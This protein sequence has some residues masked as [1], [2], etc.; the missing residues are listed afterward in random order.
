[1][2]NEDDPVA[3]WKKAGQ[4]QQKMADWL[5]SRDQ[6]TLTG[7]NVALK[8]SL[9]NASSSLRWAVQLPGWGNFHRPGGRL[10]G[11]WVRFKYPAIE[12]GQEVTDIQLWFEQGRVVKEAA[13]KNQELLTAQ[14][15][16]DAGARTLANSDW[17]QLWYHAFHQE[18]ALR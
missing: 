17:H 12:Y 8:M 1:M 11:G 9:R 10:G 2:L 15:N 13:S 14:L 18:H 7:A 6:V 5:K 16:S 4:E 3:Y